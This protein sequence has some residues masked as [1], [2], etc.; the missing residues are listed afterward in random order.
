MKHVAALVGVLGVTMIAT[1]CRAPVE[2]RPSEDGSELPIWEFLPREE[3]IALRDGFSWAETAEV[4]E[5][6]PHPNEPQGSRPALYYALFYVETPDH[7]LELDELQLHVSSLPIF[8]DEW[9]GL[10]D[11][12][13]VKFTFEGDGE[14]MFVYTILPGA[15]YNLIRRESIEGEAPLYRAVILRDPPAEALTPIGTL[16]YEYLVEHGFEWGGDLFRE[17]LEPPWGLEP[18]AGRAA[19]APEEP[20]SELAPGDSSTERRFGRR[21][22]R[23]V[24][25]LRDAIRGTVDRAREALSRV[26]RVV[27]PETEL[28]LN[29]VA[30]EADDDFGGGTP[31]SGPMIRAWGAA[32]GAPLV[33]SGTRVNVREFGGLGLSRGRTDGAGNVRIDVTRS[34][35]VRVC[36]EA[37][38]DA[39]VV[40]RSILF[41]VLACGGAFRAEGA[42][43]VRPVNLLDN[44]FNILA[45]AIDGF[46]Y[47][48]RVLGFEPRRAVIQSGFVGR[49]L[50]LPGGASFSPCLARRGTA[51][52]E[53]VA[54]AL[55]GVGTVVEFVFAVDIVMHPDERDSR[56]IASH[57]YGHYLLCEIMLQTNPATFGLVW[58]DIIAATVLAGQPPDSQ[59]VV[60][61]EGFADWF[62]AQV[63]GGVSYFSTAVGVAEEDN[64]FY[65]EPSVVASGGGLEDNLGALPCGAPG[66]PPPLACQ[67]TPAAT[68]STD[69]LGQN[70]A[71]TA[72]TLQDVVDGAPTPSDNPGAAAFWTLVGGTLVP[73]PAPVSSAAEGEV[74]RL[75]GPQLVAALRAWAV[76]PRTTLRFDA[77]YRQLSAVMRAS[78]MSNDQICDVYELHN[79]NVCPDWL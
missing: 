55:F 43:M 46:E 26:V 9:K 41:P 70:V 78:G 61:N 2:L 51:L 10:Q 17:D 47:S 69:R 12:L 34:L 19:T 21:L 45:Q 25:R 14:G 40:D 54:T 67:A 73:S 31:T 50:T 32:A 5:L 27:A 42:T 36:V 63:A 23:A 4:K 3:S 8:E 59:P 18:D 7:L 16:S 62:A 74:A 28:R 35:R 65:F 6:E 33:F 37:A 49:L 64:M 56:G 44:D 79:L 53:A 39:A 75:T 60:F 68:V 48:R 38:S 66:S 15:A 57:E 58:G 52:T 71:A 22:R 77:V 24:R 29:I 20:M 76:V 1:G 30:I 13:A 72:A 11:D